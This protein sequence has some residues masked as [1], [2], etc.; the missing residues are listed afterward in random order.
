MWSL[1]RK[2]ASSYAEGLAHRTLGRIAVSS[3]GLWIAATDANGDVLVMRHDL[4][5]SPRF[6]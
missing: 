2:S 1:D 3:D 5:R 4:N 6:A